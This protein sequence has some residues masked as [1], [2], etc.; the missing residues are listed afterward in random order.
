MRPLR[1]EA[2][3]LLELLLATFVS[4]LLLGALYVAMELQIRQAQIGREAIEQGQLAH[5]LLATMTKDAKLCVTPVAPMPTR[6]RP[7]R[8]K[9]SGTRAPGAASGSPPWGPGIPAPRPEL[10]PRRPRQRRAI[11]FNSR[12]GCRERRP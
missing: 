6:S 11:R 1:R 2:F 10:P 3:T 7:S 12:S 9:D 4:V 5:A 8:S